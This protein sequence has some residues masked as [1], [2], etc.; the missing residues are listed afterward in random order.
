[1]D[2]YKDSFLPQFPWLQGFAFRA[3]NQN[4]PQSVADPMKIAASTSP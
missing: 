3:A 2:F 1:M 4:P